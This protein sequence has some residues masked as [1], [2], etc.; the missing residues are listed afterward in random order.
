MK[1]FIKGKYI[2]L[3][4]FHSFWFNETEQK[5]H[6]VTTI[7]GKPEHWAEIYIYMTKNEYET[8][9]SLISTRFEIPQ[10]YQESK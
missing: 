2:N 8:I 9:C 3:D 6:F 7:S 4:K 10:Y 1:M 5:A